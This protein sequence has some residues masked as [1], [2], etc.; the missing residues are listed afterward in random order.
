MTSYLWSGKFLDFLRFRTPEPLSVWA[1]SH[2]IIPAAG[3]A[4]PGPWRTDRTP[5]FK[6]IM[7][8]VTDPRIRQIVVCSGIQLGKTELIL[9]TCLYH[10]LHDPAPML[11]VEP[12]DD[13]VTDIGADRIDAMIRDTPALRPLFGL[14]DDA[15]AKS[16][17]TGALKQYNKRFPG[18]YLKLASAHSESDLVSRS[19]RVIMCDEIDK[20]PT[21]GDSSAV[22]RATGRSSNFTN[23]KLILTSSPSTLQGSEIWR[24]LALTA[25]YEYQ[26]PC[27]HCGAGVVWSWS[28]VKWDKDAD[29]VS[30]AA[31]ARIECPHCGGVIKGGGPASD[32]HLATGSWVLTS[33]DR[34]RGAVGYHMS[35]LLSP[36]LPLTSIVDEFLA[37]CHNRDLDR[38]KTF[39]TD[40]LAEPWDD[41]PAPWHAESTSPE[42][43]RFEQTARHETV[44]VLTAGVD[45]QR[46][47]VEISF[48]GWGSNRESWAIRHDVV[49][50][51]TSLAATWDRVARVLF[52]PIDLADGRKMKIAAACVDSGDGVLTQM[53]YRFT[54]QYEDRHVVSIKGRGGEQTP[55]FSAPSRRN[56]NRAILY[57]LGVDRIK[58]V[59]ADRLRIKTRG[60]GYVHIPDALSGEFWA[61]LTA[62]Q[63]ETY[64]ERGRTVSSWKKLRDRNEALDCAV[65]AFAA[66]ELFCIGRRRAPAVKARTRRRLS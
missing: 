12:S 17:K 10:M 4:E 27:Q 39:V 23:S 6:Q 24:R 47:R 38:L 7:D 43:S 66:F 60:P 30:D 3:G 19:I 31:T 58:D 34:S 46:D 50:G 37:A 64:I 35:S 54:V 51:D 62:E 32:R 44:A 56:A 2:R 21:F 52:Q 8:D 5:Y 49:D 63:K 42:K 53:V 45:V 65:Y 48:W 9:N 14:K 61:Q 41:R 22:D 16:T 15:K 33:G 55:M 29:G 11:L 36:W 18:G 28:C 40:R 57:V 59:I 26:V 13:L 20:Y 1:D 25:R